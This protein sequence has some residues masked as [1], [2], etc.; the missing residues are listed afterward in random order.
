[1]TLEVRRGTAAD[2]DAAARL[3][4]VA[5]AESPWTRWTVAAD[6]HSERIGSLQRLVMEGAVLPF[7]EVWV[8]RDGDVL[9]GVAMWMLPDRVPPPTVWE[10]MR[11]ATARLE[12]DR[13]PF[14]EA[15]ERLVARLRPRH[16]HFALG[17]LGVA[18]DRQRQGI[19]TRLVSPVL[20]RADRE[21]VDAYLETSTESNVAFYTGLGFAVSGEC[22]IPDGGPP[23]WAMTRAPAGSVRRQGTET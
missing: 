15:A 3:L 22:R 11:A 8:A 18:P 16:R 19:A 14:S 4:G 7:G 21:M 5:F 6:R 1:M 10:E 13:H 17:A 2:V 9:V 12:G 20:G 23:V